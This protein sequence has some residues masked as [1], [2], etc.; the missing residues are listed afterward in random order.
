MDWIGSLGCLSG[1]F[2][3]QVV[4][5]SVG[6]CAC[7]GIVEKI[8]TVEKITTYRIS[9]PLQVNVGSVLRVNEELSLAV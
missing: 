6:L 4:C 3:W 5:G 2:V 9:D 7:T 8:R 1:W